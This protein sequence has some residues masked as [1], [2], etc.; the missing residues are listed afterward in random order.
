MAGIQKANIR[1]W[2]V[3]FERLGARWNEKSVVLSPH[4]Q[5]WR[6]RRSQVMLIEGIAL[7]IGL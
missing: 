6:L 2:H 1:I 7:D 4:G 5:Q 3:T